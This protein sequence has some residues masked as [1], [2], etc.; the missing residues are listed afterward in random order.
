MLKSC[1][2]YVLSLGPL[3]SW[4]PYPVSSEPVQSFDWILFSFQTKPP[5]QRE[6]TVTFG[7]Q[8][9]SINIH[10]LI[11]G[12]AGW[13]VFTAVIQGQKLAVVTKHPVSISKCL[14]TSTPH[15]FTPDWLLS[16]YSSHPLEHPSASLSLLMM[17]HP[18]LSHQRFSLLVL[19]ILPVIRTT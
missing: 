5:P 10:W 3:T 6:K 1:H 16:F 2:T 13:H 14:S 9:N 19:V 17:F 7:H 12:E 18:S 15:A 4:A 8:D 11:F